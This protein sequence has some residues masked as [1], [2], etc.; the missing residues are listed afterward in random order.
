MGDRAREGEHDPERLNFSL[1][2]FNQLE[3]PDASE[4]GRSIRSPG[5]K[6]EASRSGSSRIA[7]D[8]VP[9]KPFDLRAYV[10]SKVSFCEGSSTY[11][12]M[13]LRG[14]FEARLRSKGIGWC[15][16]AKGTTS[17]FSEGFMLSAVR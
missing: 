12:T 4:A 15:G 5:E 1:S 9:A 10:V 14:S 16:I 17:Q 3:L 2:S 6:W 11:N 13:P 7:P 8:M